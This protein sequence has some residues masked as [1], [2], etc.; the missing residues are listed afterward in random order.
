MCLLIR[1]QRSDFRLK[2]IDECL[3]DLKI[4]TLDCE[5][6]ASPCM[7][8]RQGINPAEQLVSLTAR[9]L[10]HLIRERV[11]L[12]RGFL[13][14]CRVSVRLDAAVGEFK[15]VSLTLSGR[16]RS[17]LGLHRFFRLY[18]NSAHSW[19]FRL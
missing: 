3:L 5:A 7:L 4:A 10:E 2:L 18:F 17:L 11:S 15:F 9:R 12:A 13:Q 19:A 14:R 6:F 16:A 1:G 8:G